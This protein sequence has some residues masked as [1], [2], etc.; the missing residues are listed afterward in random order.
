LIEFLTI[1]IL[2][3][4]TSPFRKDKTTSMILF[5]ELMQFSRLREKN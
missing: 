4:I 2:T 5:R 3:F 1:G